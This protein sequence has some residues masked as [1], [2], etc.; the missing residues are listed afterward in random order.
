M[1]AGFLLGALAGALISMPVSATDY[2]DICQ[3]CG[4]G[5]DSAS[6]L[7]AAVSLAQANGAQAGDG[8]LLCKDFPGGSS[9]VHV[10]LVDSS[11]VL[12]SGDITLIDTD[13]YIDLSCADLG[14]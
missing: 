11:P 7:A 14:F 5:G 13:G 2:S 9:V 10:Y 4:G 3:S 6:W 12:D 1:K 8:L